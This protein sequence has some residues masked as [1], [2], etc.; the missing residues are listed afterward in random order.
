MLNL[1]GFASRRKIIPFHSKR[2]AGCWLLEQ[3][4]KKSGAAW[5][6]DDSRAI[7]VEDFGRAGGFVMLKKGE[8]NG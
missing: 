5:V 6:S 8:N 4:F 2:V 1:Q 7:W 3:G